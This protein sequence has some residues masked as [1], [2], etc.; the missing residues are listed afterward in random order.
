MLERHVE[1]TNF[2]KKLATMIA[3]SAVL[4]CYPAFSDDTF[5]FDSEP[6]KLANQIYLDTSQ[7][8]K[9]TPNTSIPFNLRQFSEADY[10][11]SSIDESPPPINQNSSPKTSQLEAPNFDLDKLPS[12]SQFESAKKTIVTEQPVP[13]KSVQTIVPVS[14]PSQHTGFIDNGFAPLPT[15]NSFFSPVVEKQ[16]ETAPAQAPILEEKVAEEVIEAVET[17]TEEPTLREILSKDSEEK[18][19]VISEVSKEPVNLDLDGRII[20]SVEFKG[21]NTIDE[22]VILSE[23][24]IQ[25]GAL[26]NQELIQKDLQKI[27]AM[28]FFSDEM[29]VEPTLRPDGDIDLRYILKENIFV[30]VNIQI[31]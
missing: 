19:S 27:Y 12:P 9:I 17:S 20:A 28:G 5:L 7:T 10:F 16:E 1:K 22:D 2:N 14:Y 3:L 15:A 11:S 6:I 30:Y 8:G 13:V 26:F 18:A 4:S 25:E 24:N 29:S 31:K 21:L 23:I